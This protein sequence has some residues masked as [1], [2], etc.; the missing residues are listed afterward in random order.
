MTDYWTEAVGYIRK[1]EAKKF[2]ELI[3][4]EL[5]EAEDGTPEVK[6]IFDQVKD[7]VEDATSED[8]Y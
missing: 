4:L 7:K 2:Y 8:Y 6:K 3:K 1:G 5:R